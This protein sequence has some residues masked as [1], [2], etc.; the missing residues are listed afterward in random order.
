LERLET[1]P[2]RACL[3]AT[4]TLLLRLT[5]QDDEAKAAA[6]AFLRLHPDNPVA[7]AESAIL[8]AADQGGRVALEY[9]Q[10]AIAISQNRMHGRLYEAMAVLARVLAAE[11]Q[12]LA[13]RALTLLQITLH[14]DD[15]RPLEFMVQLNASPAV[16]LLVKDDRTLAEAPA[17][18]AW[19]P[20]FDKVLELTNLGQLAAAAERFA[21]LAAENPDA[22]PIWHNLAMVR[23]WAADL[24]GA[25]QAWRKYAA[26]NVGLEEAAEAEALA[27]FFSEGDPLGDAM[28]VVD[29]EYPVSDAEALNVA[30]L[31]SPR[32]NLLRV[33]LSSMVEEGE[34]PPKSAFY[35]FDRPLPESGQPQ[36][37]ENVPVVLG[38]LLLWGK[39]T[40]REARV[41]AL[42]LPTSALDA[43]QSYLGQLG[44]SLLGPPSQTVVDRTSATAELLHRNF[45][46]RDDAGEDEAQQILEQYTQQTLYR[47]WPN[48][49]LG[50]LDGKTPQQAAADD[51]YRT[52][53]QGAILV[54]EFMAAQTSNQLDANRLRA[55]LGLPSFGPIDPAQTAVDRLPLVRLARVEVEQLTDEQLLS[56]YRR[57]LAFTAREAAI[58]LARSIIQRPSLAEKHDEREQAFALLARQAVHAAE[59]IS[60][61]DQGR[62]ESTA[63][64][65]SCAS[66][67]LM[68]LGVRFE[69]REPAEIS[70]LLTHLQTRH[71]REPGVA[72]ALNRWLMSIGAIRPDGTPAVPLQQAAEAAANL[73][74]PGQAAAEPG[75]IW[76]PGSAT[77][78]GEK[79]KL[80]TP[81]M[82]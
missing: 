13:A 63:S 8:T 71:L 1:H 82:G 70:R 80:W 62:Q 58:R 66:W 45:R 36:T 56:C 9:L 23:A 49:P 46:L 17:G 2:N 26:L 65:R 31:S 14:Q 47:Q 53:V 55:Q 28:D 42:S 11:G 34:P 52:R 59:A 38:Q 7:L 74:A 50:V 37:V 43:V 12:F 29:L 18:A 35:V 75:K 21:A 44:G 60:Y 33:D 51:A 4:K 72:Q 15:P 27:M 68:E 64:G 78:P 32:A 57:A 30:L 81:D 61:I 5:G 10:R 19:K 77:L 22:P 48:L 41:V 54:L 16:P 6:A 76:T 3:L 67:D 25:A 20:A 79:P 40:D 69:S 39:Q 24:P 73:T